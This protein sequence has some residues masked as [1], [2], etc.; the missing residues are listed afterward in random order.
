MKNLA[1]CT[2]REF[3]RQTNR[4]RKAAE[5]WLKTTKVLELR[6]KLPTRAEGLTDQEWD[7]IVE[8]HMN[9]T[10]HKM[11]DAV[12]EEHP[13]ETA[14]LLGLLC[15]IEP[16]HLDEH[17]VAELMESFTELMNCREVVDFFIS[18]TRLGQMNGFGAVRAPGLT[19]SSSAGAAI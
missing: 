3:L 18:L 8:A 19:S 14:E 17:S 9:A 7:E 13:D 1:N 15:F 12:L 10:L 5:G 2:P 4:I 16:E 11:L 6:R